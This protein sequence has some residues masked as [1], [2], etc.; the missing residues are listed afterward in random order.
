M[1]RMILNETSYFGCGCRSVI[2][3]EIK[4]R[5][6]KKVLVVTDPALL[7]I[8][9]AQEVTAVLDKAG[10]AYEVFQA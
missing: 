6:F 8:G 10:I 1:N 5:G 2:A 3:D 4:N 7:K 9:V